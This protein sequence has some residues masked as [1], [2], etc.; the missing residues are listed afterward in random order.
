MNLDVGIGDSQ[1]LGI[2]IDSDELNAA[3][4][5]FDH[6]VDGVGATATYTHHLDDGKIIIDLVLVHLTVLRTVGK[7]LCGYTTLTLK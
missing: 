3:D 6:A 7:A 1:R 4:A 2:G 5:L